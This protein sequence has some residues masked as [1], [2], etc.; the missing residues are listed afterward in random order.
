MSD[1]R[2][3]DKATAKLLIDVSRETW[4]RLE[5]LVATLDRWQAVTNLV[6]PSTLETVWT[7]HVA[8]SA[9]LIALAPKAP[10][11]WVDLGSGAGFPGLVVTA[12]LAGKTEVHLVESNGKKAAFLREAARHMGVRV[13]VHA[14]RAEQAIAGLSAGV[15]SARALAALPELVALAEPLLKTGAIGLF[16]KGREAASELTVTQKSWRFS[17]SLHPS[18]TDPDA[19]IVRVDGFKGRREA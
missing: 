7:R 18:L 5:Q 10:T 12:M 2:A 11:A 1:V 3:A 19:S 4:A 17:G 13:T 14:A 6:A 16:P 8:D 9:Q 15:V